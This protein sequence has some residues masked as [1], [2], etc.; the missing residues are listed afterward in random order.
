MEIS[1]FFDAD[2]PERKVADGG[3]GRTEQYWCP[4]KHAVRLKTRH[5]RY[6][7]F[8]DYG[9]AAHYHARLEVIRREFLDLKAAP[10][11]P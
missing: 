10:T 11:A 4:I 3:R 5:S 6:Q 2:G 8:V 9:D 1:R 7:H